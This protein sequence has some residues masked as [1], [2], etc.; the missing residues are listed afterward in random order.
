MLQ[1]QPLPM[2]PKSPITW[3]AGFLTWGA[4]MKKNTLYMHTKMQCDHIQTQ[5]YD[6]E[7]T[8]TLKLKYDQ[9]GL[10]LLY[11]VPGALC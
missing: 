4:G 9:L 11:P 1:K 3:E 10:Y 5:V 7:H 6:N 8:R 2:S